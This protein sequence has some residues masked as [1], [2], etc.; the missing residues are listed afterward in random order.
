MI[1]PEMDYPETGKNYSKLINKYN[2]ERS[3]M[4]LLD[5]LLEA[6]IKKIIK[7]YLNASQMDTGKIKILFDQSAIMKY[8][9]KQMA[10]EKGPSLLSLE[11]Q[12]EIFMVVTAECYMDQLLEYDSGD[13]VSEKDFAKLHF[14]AAVMAGVI[15]DQWPSSDYKIIRIDLWQKH[16]KQLNKVGE[17]ITKQPSSTS[18]FVG[19][20]FVLITSNVEA[21]ILI[22]PN[23]YPFKEIE[24]SILEKYD[25]V[26]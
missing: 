25:N 14:C 24:K 12:I 7:Q 2:Q 8:G 5:F 4:G 18:P 13:I 1:N 22:L 17:A 3:G 23:D 26:S 20:L 16:W 15:S 6:K 9:I 10:S 21:G 11:K 19:V